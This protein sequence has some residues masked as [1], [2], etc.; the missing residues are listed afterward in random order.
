[1]V[2][3]PEDDIVIRNEVILFY[4]DKKLQRIYPL[5]NVANV[6]RVVEKEGGGK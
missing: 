1:M 6:K 3:S 2:D 4:D 5:V